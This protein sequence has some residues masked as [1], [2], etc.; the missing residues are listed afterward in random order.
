MKANEESDTASIMSIESEVSQGPS[1]GIKYRGSDFHK[2]GRRLSNTPAAIRKRRERERKKQEK[3]A[4]GADE[5]NDAAS[6]ASVETKT[7]KAPST[8]SGIQSTE[9]I[10]SFF[11]TG[12][13]LSNTPAAIWKRN[14]RERKKQMEV[15]LSRDASD[16]TSGAAVSLS[17]STQAPRG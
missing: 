1:T 12:R 10:N 15:A 17:E 8:S 6:V 14:E 9:A 7:S 3:E 16:G 13:R 5:D 11:Q 4:N 2:I